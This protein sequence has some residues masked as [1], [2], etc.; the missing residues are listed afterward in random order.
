MIDPRLVRNTTRIAMANAQA[1]AWE[2]AHAAWVELAT[3]ELNP[4]AAEHLL[5]ELSSTE[6][7]AYQAMVDGLPGPETFVR[8][9]DI[10]VRLGL[11]ARTLRS[12]D[13]HYLASAR[14]SVYDALACLRVGDL[15]DASE[16]IVQAH[17]RLYWLIYER[18][19]EGSF[20]DRRFRDSATHETLAGLVE[21]LSAFV[22]ELAGAATRVLIT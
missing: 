18:K 16:H 13:R 6:R 17:R 11:V 1:L 4:F 19:R 3:A 10:V 22:S 8:L 21:E 12:E 14:C 5:A 9:D 15:E 7:A 2:A 20:L